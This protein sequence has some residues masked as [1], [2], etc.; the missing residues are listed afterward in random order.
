[1]RPGL[2]RSDVPQPCTRDAVPQLDTF[3]TGEET[4]RYLFARSAKH[5]GISVMEGV[6]GLYD[7]V[8]GITDQASAV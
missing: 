5:A 8:G 6:M 3:F 4:T 2:Y 7:G 1:M